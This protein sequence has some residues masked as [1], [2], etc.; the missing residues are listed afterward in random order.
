MHG[1][2]SLKVAWKDVEPAGYDQV[3]LAAHDRQNAIGVEAVPME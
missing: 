1:G 2:D 3:L